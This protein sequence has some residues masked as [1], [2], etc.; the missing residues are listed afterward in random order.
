M[1]SVSTGTKCFPAAFLLITMKYVFAIAFLFVASA[2]NAQS[3]TAVHQ[4]AKTA[5]VYKNLGATVNSSYSELMP[6]ITADGSKLFFVRENHPQ[7][8]QSPQETQDIWFCKREPD[9]GWS[10]AK[11]LGF[12]FNTA[13]NNS[14]F[15]QSPDGTQRIIRGVFEKSER[16]GDGFSVSRLTA[17]G[18]S[19]PQPLRMHG[20]ERLS[21]GIYS[22]M[23]MSVDNRTIILYFSRKEDSSINDL[24][25][26]HLIG[27]NEWS[28]PEPLGETINTPGDESTPF[29]AADGVTLYFSSDKPGGFG[30]ADIWV[31]RRLDDTWTKWS[32]PVNL[33]PTVN[34]ERWQAYYSIAAAGNVAY[35]VVGA[36]NGGFGGTD[37]CTIEP[38]KADQPKPV[39]LISGRVFSSKTNLPVSAAVNYFTLPDGAEAGIAQSNPQ[40]GEYQIVLP[41]GKLYGFKAAAN[42]YYAVSENIDLTGLTTYTELKRDLALTPIETGQIVRLNNIFFETGKAELRPESFAE[43][44]NLVKVLNDNLSM[45][46]AIAGHTDDVGSDEANMKLSDD[47]AQ[48]VMNYLISKGIQAGRLSAKGFGESKPVVQNTSDENRAQN[49]RVEFT[50]V[51]K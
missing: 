36:G 8:T 42:G 51:S 11:H 7:N 5:P 28:K 30:S 13:R 44:D 1:H 15:Y 32:E 29:L 2:L 9:G 37:I 14:I 12:P 45:N 18:W 20:Y 43:L 10:E 47:R 4:S 33:G 27:G 24:Y 16:I 35:V 22:G 25:V 39:A 49:R 17:K 38:Q 40:N 3:A 50:I 26:S 34:D 23:C 19:D 46:I 41:A 31:S 6:Y 48:A 21:K